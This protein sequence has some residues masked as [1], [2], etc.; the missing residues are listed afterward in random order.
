MIETGSQRILGRHARLSGLELS[1]SILPHCIAQEVH[2]SIGIQGQGNRIP[3][4]D[5]RNYTV[6]SYGVRILGGDNFGPVLLSVYYIMRMKLWVA[7]S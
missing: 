4:L 6:T 3:F 5:E 2:M 1:Y 7:Q